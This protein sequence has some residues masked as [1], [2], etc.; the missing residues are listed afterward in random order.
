MPAS[1]SLNTKTYIYSVAPPSILELEASIDQCGIQSKIYRDPY[2]SKDSDAPEKSREYSGLLYHLR[3]Q[4]LGTLEEWDNGDPEAKGKSLG[5]FPRK[6]EPFGISGWEYASCPPSVG[7]SKKW[8]RS[9]DSK[10]RNANKE[11]VQSQVG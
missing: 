11:K 6:L 9:D 2:Y 3:G 10:L 8:L 7:E 1:T 4:G 5:A